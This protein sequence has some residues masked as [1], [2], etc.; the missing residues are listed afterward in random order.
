MRRLDKN[1]FLLILIAFLSL[2]FFYRIYGLTTNYSFWNDEENV[3][4][5]TRA[6]L[7]RGYPVLGNGFSTG[8]YKWLQYWLS[9]GSA[10][11]FGLNEFAVRFPSVIFGVLTI[12]AVYLLGKELFNKKVAL[13]SVFFV[14]FLK[15]EILW[16]RQ[17]RPYQSLQFFYLLGAF[18]LYKFVQN[19]FN[20]KYF[21]G[22]LI[23]CVLASLMH[24]LGLC[25]FLIGLFYIALNLKG[26]F[27]KRKLPWLLLNLI[28][29]ITLAY[30][31]RDYIFSRIKG[32]GD[33]SNFFYY[34]VFLTH[35]YLWITFSAFLGSVWLG[36]KRE[37]KKLLIFLLFIGI[38]TIVVSFFLFQPFTRYFYIIFP[39]I[40]LLAAFFLDELSGFFKFKNKIGISLLL[41]FLVLLLVFTSKNKLALLPQKTYSL[42]EDMQEVPEV[43]YKKIYAF[44]EKKLEDN[45]EAIFISNWFDHPIWYLGEGKLDYWLRIKDFPEQTK[46]AFSGSILVDNLNFLKEIITKEKKGLIILE[47]WESQ[48]PP[49]TVEYIRSNL[50]K[51]FEYDR[52]YS[53]QPRYWPVEVYSWGIDK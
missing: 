5:F 30:F 40:I 38:Q 14:T 15:I 19:K 43:D 25:L 34:R 12:W 8:V 46:D 1:K 7:Q 6:I 21:W 36:L 35:N 29:L 47:S 41:I 52:L 10:K 2:G 18:F 33:Y 51:E 53:I 22:F 9:A 37:Y 23:C 26:Y 17:A 44:I 16:S 28:G 20:L 50:K 24:G 13:I 11:I 31:L 45:P 42:N 3:A 48:L 39:F 27:D 32:F 49:G 4:T